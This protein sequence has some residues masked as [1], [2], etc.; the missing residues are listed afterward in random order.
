MCE[1]DAIAM[2]NTAD[3]TH[4]RAAIRVP[5]IGCVIAEGGMRVE[6]NRVGA[7]ASMSM[8]EDAPTSSCMSVNAQTNICTCIVGTNARSQRRTHAPTCRSSRENPV[9][10]RLKTARDRV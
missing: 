7:F 2:T 4:A 5:R 1:H 3:A 6:V 10:Q 8:R 9:Q